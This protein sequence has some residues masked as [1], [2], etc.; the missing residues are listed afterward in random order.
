MKSINSLSSECISL[1]NKNKLLKTLIQKEL[2]NNKLSKVNLNETLEQEIIRKFTEKLEL[3][4][5][6]P[7]EDW[8]I[9]NKLT[10][11]DLYN[12]AL[13]SVRLK[14]YCKENYAHK[15][16]SRFLT[17]KNELDMIVYS[18]I[19]VRE[20]FMARELYLRIS[21]KE[22]DF[23]DLAAE[24][25]E[26]LEKKT[27]G[28]VG[29]CPIGQAHPELRLILQKSKPGVI[30]PPIKIEDSIVIV[31]VESNDPAQL[32]DFMREKM[33]EEIFHE[34]IEVEANQINLELLKTSNLE[35]ISNSA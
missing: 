29:P 13:Q 10:K 5:K 27:R 32:D 7:L 19:R 26:G 21:E 2:I 28:I 35:K 30:H 24:Y 3:S 15:L 12:H 17:R 22:A 14:Q 18:L 33:G 31:R 6:M 8:L 16:D 34:S 25:S 23:S 9:N 20:F 1:L 4:V 11:N